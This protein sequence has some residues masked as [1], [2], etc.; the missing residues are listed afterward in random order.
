MS[1]PRLCKAGDALRDQI[2]AK[3]PKRDKAS[4]GWVADARHMDQGTSDHIPDANGIVRAIDIDH[5][6]S[7]TDKLAMGVLVEKLRKQAET[8]GRIAYIIYAGRI[9]SPRR[10]GPKMR[11]WL[12]RPYTGA[13]PHNH[14]AHLSFTRRGDFSGLPFDI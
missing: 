8:D 11:P 3:W 2:N 13:N 6:L 12:W 9:A 1:K 14:H 4:D 5:D 10:S 7:K